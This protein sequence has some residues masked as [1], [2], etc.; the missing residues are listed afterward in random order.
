MSVQTGA[1]DND[2]EATETLGRPTARTRHAVGDV[3]LLP[4]QFVAA[5]LG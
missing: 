5:T 1:A 4:Q 2:V 3:Q